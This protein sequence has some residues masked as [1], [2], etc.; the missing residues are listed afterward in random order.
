MD[1]DL[2]Q[3]VEAALANKQKRRD[4]EDR[5]YFLAQRIQALEPWGNFT[6]PDIDQLGGYRLWFYQIPHH[7]MKLLQNLEQPWQ[8]DF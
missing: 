3:V 6:L 5:R 2:D 1:F 8:Q 4:T 7:K